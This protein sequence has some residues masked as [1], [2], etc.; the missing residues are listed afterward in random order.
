MIDYG[1]FDH[2]KS[3]ID[4]STNILILQADNPDADSLA[5]SLALEQ[6]LSDLGKN[7]Y[8]YCS[9]EMPKYLRYLNGWDRVSTD[10]PSHFDVSILVDCSAESLL[11]NLKNNQVY[12][13]IMKKPLIILDHHITEATL[14]SEY[15][16]VIQT[17]SSGE[18]IYEL[19]KEFNWGLNHNA[20]NQILSSIM[21]DSLG[22][23][24]ESTTYRSIE[25]VAELVKDGVSIPEIEEKRRELMKKSPRLLEYKAKL[26]ERINYSEDGRIAYIHIPWEEIETYSNEYNPSMLVIDEMRQVEGVEAVIAFKSYKQGRLTGKI[27]ANYGHPIADKLAEKFGGGGHKYASGFKIEDVSDI[28]AKIVDIINFAE[29]LLN[30][31]I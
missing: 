28:N 18:L 10:F 26:I 11:D 2:I 5:S 16:C 17:V 29:Q 13:S 23:T 22:L 6:I 25:I 3:L 31:N 20:K 8:M 7:T 19:S 24:T 4:R 14:T 30:E 12:S 9:I 15:S 27:R 21:S 1:K